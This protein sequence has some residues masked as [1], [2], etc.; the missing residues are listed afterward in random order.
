MA[1]RTAVI[2]NAKPLLSLLVDDKL[3]AS[4][5][6]Q[7]TPELWSDNRHVLAIAVA[8]MVRFPTLHEIAENNPIGLR[9]FFDKVNNPG[10]GEILQDLRR[11]RA[12]EYIPLWENGHLREF[13]V[14]LRGTLLGADSASVLGTAEVLKAALGLSASVSQ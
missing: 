9:I 7:V 13:L 12:A 11:T 6:S 3:V 2:I 1:D 5:A 8:I 10:Q 4:L 14:S